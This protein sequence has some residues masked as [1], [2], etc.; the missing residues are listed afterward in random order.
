MW[1]HRLAW[2]NWLHSSRFSH[3]AAIFRIWN[4]TPSQIWRE[5]RKCKNLFISLAVIMMEVL[6]WPCRKDRNEVPYQFV[7]GVLKW[8]CK[9]ITLT[10]FPN[11][12]KCQKINQEIKCHRILS[13]PNEKLTINNYWSTKNIIIPKP[14]IYYPLKIIIFFFLKK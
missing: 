9:D 8:K 2:D 3:I 12:S 14:K 6:E 5:G 4:W 10:F 11:S 1:L 13:I 7:E